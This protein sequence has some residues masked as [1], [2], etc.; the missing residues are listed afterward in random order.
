MSLA[1]VRNIA[2]ILVLA[3]LIVVLPGGGTGA[4]VAGQAASLAFLGTMGWFASVQY[5]QH[6]VTLYS[7]G[8]T[9]RAILYASIAVATLTLTATPRLWATGGGSVAWLVL[10]GASAYALIAVI[11][12]ARKYD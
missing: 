7:L 2:I 8:G 12:H 11:L 5:R 9:R 3:A 1:T 4:A 6:R 10:L